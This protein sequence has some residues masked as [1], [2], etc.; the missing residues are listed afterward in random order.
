MKLLA[1]FLSESNQFP[2]DYKLLD[3]E[4]PI[5]L[6]EEPIHDLRVADLVC[7]TGPTNRRPPIVLDSVYQAAISDGIFQVTN[8]GIAPRVMERAMQGATNFFELPIYRL[9]SKA[10]ELKS[11]YSD[12]YS[13]SYVHFS[14]IYDRAKYWRDTVFFYWPSQTSQTVNIPDHASKFNSSVGY[15]ASKVRPLAEKL[16]S[17]ISERLELGESYFD[18]QGLTSV[19]R[20]NINSYPRCPQ[21]ALTCGIPQHRNPD[22]LT[23]TFESGANGIQVFKNN[24]WQSVKAQQN[25]LIVTLGSQMQVVS[26]NVLKAPVHRVLVNAERG[27]TSICYAIA[28]S[29]KTDVKPAAIGRPGAE[30]ARYRSYK[31]S[32]YLENHMTN[33]RDATSVVSHFEV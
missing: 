16:L 26:N 33:Y 21:P 19:R 1:E 20:L 4:L 3:R 2:L 6:Y 17:F 30:P 7:L 31:Y 22:L 10:A 32:K 14:G 5:P 11:E 27:R 24:Q 25:A 13:G 29:N 23:I 12:I 18:E 15:Y 28:P 8:H 9:K